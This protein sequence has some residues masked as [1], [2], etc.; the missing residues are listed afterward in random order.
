M[1]TMMNEENSQ[2]TDAKLDAN[3]IIFNKSDESFMTTGKSSS[4]KNFEETPEFSKTKAEILME[5][6]GENITQPI[7]ER[8]RLMWQQIYQDPYLHRIFGSPKDVSVDNQCSNIV[9]EQTE[10]SK[11][12]VES[13]DRK[14]VQH[15]ANGR[16]RLWLSRLGVLKS[17]VASGQEPVASNHLPNDVQS[18]CD[19]L[20]TMR[21]I[22]LP[23]DQNFIDKHF[24]VPE[25]DNLKPEDPA[26]IYDSINTFE[27]KLENVDDKPQFH[28]VKPVDIP[29]KSL[30]SIEE[31]SQGKEVVA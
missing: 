31:L 21:K 4:K 17:Q 1:S 6:K 27:K 3:G 29:G 13:T 19:I 2:R 10:K 23:P 24:S 22:K 15:W 11:A 25:S 14:Q 20:E 26:E 7:R 16:L 18:V 5:F 9:L 12:A 28:L 30:G 8:C